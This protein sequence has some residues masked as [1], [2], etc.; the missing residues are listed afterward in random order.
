[1][2]R[3]S[4]NRRLNQPRA[5]KSR[6]GLQWRAIILVAIC[7]AL[8]CL[9]WTML[10]RYSV[11]R[12]ADSRG[13]EFSVQRYLYFF[14]TEKDVAIGSLDHHAAIERILNPKHPME[15]RDR[16]RQLTEFL[17]GMHSRYAYRYV[18]IPEDAPWRLSTYQLSRED[19]LLGPSLANAQP[20]EERRVRQDAADLWAKDDPFMAR[21]IADGDTNDTLIVWPA[22]S[23]NVIWGF[24]GLAAMVLSICTVVRTIALRRRVRSAGIVCPKCHYQLT[25]LRGAERCPECGQTL[26]W[27]K[28][29]TRS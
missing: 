10:P 5:P 27:A 22:L 25:E 8:S 24:L 15:Q 19:M 23:W 2:R 14:T 11:F 7:V 28:Q 16:H 17:E 4:R 13:I 26:N 20:L 21:G 18:L 1:M 6:L 12:W 3:W 9:A 29:S